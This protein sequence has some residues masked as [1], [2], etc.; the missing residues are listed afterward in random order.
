ME[1]EMEETKCGNFHDTSHT[2]VI[3]FAIIAE[4]IFIPF[5]TE[6]LQQ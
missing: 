6:C 4:A 1:R 3:S 2:M 5:L